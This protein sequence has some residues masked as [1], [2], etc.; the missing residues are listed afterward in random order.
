MEPPPKAVFFD[1][2]G[3]LIHLPAGVGH[4]YSAAAR[5]LGWEI[6]PDQLSAV[7]A[8]LWKRLPAPAPTLRPRP[9]DGRAWW[10][11]LV[12]QLLHLAGAP[13]HFDRER[14]FE[15]VYQEFA[16]PGVWALYP[17]V[18]GVLETVARHSRL[19]ILSNFDGRLRQVLGHLGIADRFCQV[20]LS[21]EAGA[22]KPHPWIFEHALAQAGIDPAHALMVG[23]EWEADVL[24]A[25]RAGMRALHIERPRQDLRALLDAFPAWAKEHPQ[26][27]QMEAD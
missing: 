2:A 10:R 25:R 20:T 3:T 26:V 12:L 18:A 27:K 9:D 6:A 14:Y 4:H 7:F 1:A 17:E 13:P 11:D 21:S 16:R 15:E 5:R 8:H 19:A 22:D 23:D 24:G